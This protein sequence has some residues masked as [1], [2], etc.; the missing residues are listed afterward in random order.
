MGNIPGLG[1]YQ[2]GSPTKLDLSASASVT[3]TEVS[4]RVLECLSSEMFTKFIPLFIRHFSLPQPTRL[5]LWGPCRTGREDKRTDRYSGAGQEG[6]A[7]QPHAGRKCWHS[8][9]HNRYVAAQTLPV[10]WAFMR[11]S[12]SSN[13]SK[14]WSRCKEH[15]CVVARWHIEPYSNSIN[16]SPWGQQG[17]LAPVVRLPFLCLRDHTHQAQMSDAPA[18]GLYFGVCV[19][20]RAYAATFIYIDRT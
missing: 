18:Q 19:G 14:S 6:E 8:I 2:T 5:S 11:Q 1:C 20:E 7:K 9:E 13:T 17:C 15:F 10:S 3:N 12:L 4:G 16:K